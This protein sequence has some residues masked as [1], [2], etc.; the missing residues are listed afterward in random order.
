MGSGAGQANLP[1]GVAP[2][3]VCCVRWAMWRHTAQ[4][5]YPP[6]YPDLVPPLPPSPPKLID[7][8]GDQKASVQ[9]HRALSH[10]WGPG[11]RG[12]RFGGR[13]PPMD[14]RSVRY[15]KLNEDRKLQVCNMTQV[16]LPHRLLDTKRQGHVAPA[17]PVSNER[18]Q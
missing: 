14:H 9:G 7:P 15:F 13:V 10:G 5:I 17:L 11:C 6:L 16:L 12:P 4:A 8:T 3:W 18:L 1:H 2:D